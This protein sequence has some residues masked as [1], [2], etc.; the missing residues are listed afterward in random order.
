MSKLRSL[1]EPAFLTSSPVEKLQDTLTWAGGAAVPRRHGRV[2]AGPLAGGPLTA[3]LS[4]LGKQQ[5]ISE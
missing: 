4:Q 1:S 3:H 5:D 2:P